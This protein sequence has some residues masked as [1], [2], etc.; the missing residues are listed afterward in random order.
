M[1]AG[2][3]LLRWLQAPVNSWHSFTDTNLRPSSPCVTYC[4]ASKTLLSDACCKG[5]STVWYSLIYKSL[6]YLRLVAWSRPD[7]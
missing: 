3:C 6:D 7:F 2:T 1:P 4:Q 5:L